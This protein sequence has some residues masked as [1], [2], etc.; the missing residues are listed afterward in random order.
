MIEMAALAG[1]S[2]GTG[3]LNYFANKS[4][5]ER[6]EALQNE[7][8]QKWIQMAIPDPAQQRVAFQQFVSQGTFTP[9]LQSAIKQDP[10]A[11][12]KIVTDTG[13]KAAQTRALKGLEDIGFEGGLRLQDKAALQD[14]MIG[15][16][17]RERSN[18]EGIVA[19]MARRG[20]SGSGFDVASR[21]QGQQV[22]ADQQANAGLKV[23]AGAQ[24]RALAALESSGDLAS[25]YRGQDFQ[26]Q[27]AK[28]SAADRIN[29]FN[30]ENM[31]SVNAANTGI[32]NNAQQYNLG[33]K[34]RIA[35]K[36]I[37]ISN[38]QEEHNK[39]LYQQQYENQ[40]KRMSGASGASNNLAQ[41][42]LRQ[43]QNLG[44][45]ISNIGTGAIGAYS[46]ANQGSV[47]NKRADHYDLMDEYF[48]R[49][50]GYGDDFDDELDGG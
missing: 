46:A 21:L 27:S 11:F 1:V 4:A 41:T 6:A 42:A 2:A 26:E 19:E 3:L 29:A 31:R 49:K 16:Q 15:A 35:D 10:S 40:L 17:T 25:K 8:F 12:E 20:M 9:Q 22:T 45:T 48:R 30:T 44:N 33:E 34:Q 14:A 37:Q 24:D 32:A 36:N 38:A 7:Q 18:R 23:A 43:G 13:S 28:A 50:N 39:G 47:N 5:N